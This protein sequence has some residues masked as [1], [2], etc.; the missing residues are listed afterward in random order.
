VH[1]AC[2]GGWCWEKVKPLLEA[3]GHKVLTPDLPACG[4]D[5]TPIASATLGANVDAISAL[6]DKEPDPVI[7]VG[8][9]LGGVTVAMT[10]EARRRKVK[11]AVYVT[12]ILPPNGKTARDMTALEPEGLVR[13]SY[14]TVVEGVSYTFKRG[15]VQTL[16]Y[17]ECE[18]EDVYRAMARL[19]PQP[20]KIST[21]PVALTAERFGSVPRLYIECKRDN[22]LPITLQRKMTALTPCRTEKLY[23]DH[24]PFYSMPE[25]LAEL[26]HKAS[27]DA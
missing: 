20:L 5:R 11:T 26:L 13:Q 9:S 7:L 8:H 12:A 4:D 21:T 23:T 10:S 15:N 17:N 19:K 14:E 18:P 24:S 3:R 2:H 16:F 27:L 22:A 6:L 25:E 1:G